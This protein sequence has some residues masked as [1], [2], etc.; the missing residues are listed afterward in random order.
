MRKIEKYVEEKLVPVLPEGVTIEYGR[1][2]GRAQMPSWMPVS[3]TGMPM[4]DIP[5]YEKFREISVK[6]LDTIR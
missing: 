1:L 5:L 4:S 3:H 6:I 2:S